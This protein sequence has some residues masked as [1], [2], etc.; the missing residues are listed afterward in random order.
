MGLGRLHRAAR[1]AA[2]AL[3][4]GAPLSAIPPG[5]RPTARSAWTT[6]A[7][8]PRERAIAHGAR[9]LRGHGHA[10]AGSTPAGVNGLHEMGANA[11]EW[12]DEPPAPPATAPHADH[13]ASKPRQTA[14]VYSG[15]VREALRGAAQARSARPA[16]DAA[17][18]G[19]ASPLALDRAVV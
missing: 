9:L 1:G 13:R 7:R 2:R 19:A 4:G 17:D 16:A 11:W 18:A 6:A 12:V 8:P 3:R 10:R 14:V 5:N 15:A